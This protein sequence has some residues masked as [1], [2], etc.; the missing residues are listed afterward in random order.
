MTTRNISILTAIIA[1]AGCSSINWML[2]E[3]AYQNGQMKERYYVKVRGKIPEMLTA[4][5]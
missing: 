1:I 4:S 3:T 2:R 5:L